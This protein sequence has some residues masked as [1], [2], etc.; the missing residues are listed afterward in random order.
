MSPLGA[1]T[2][3]GDDGVVPGSD[4]NLI[5]DDE[6]MALAV[7]TAARVR[8]S[9]APNPWVG[10]AIRT[11]D[12]AIHTGAT[13][14]PGGAHA[15]IEAL[16]AAG[17]AAAGAT[18]ASTLEPCSHSGRTGPCTDAIIAAGIA[19]VIVGVEDP[20]ADVAGRGIARLR[21][22]GVEVEV[23]V[24]GSDVA[25]Q[26]APYLHHRR[27][28]RPY[29]VLKL[30]AT[31]DGRTAAPDGSSQWITSVDARRDAHR[32]RAESQAILVGAGTVRADNPTLTTRLV[33]G[34]DP[35]RVVL[36]TAPADA[37]VHPCLEWIGPI[38]DLLDQL[39]ADGVLQLLVEGGAGVASEFHDGGMVDRY[40]VYLAPAIFGGD[41]ARPLFV[42]AGAPTI[43][44]L[45]RGRILDA[46]R[47]GP[48]LR[49]DVVLE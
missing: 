27:T 9:T 41:D 5:S 32:L 28:G 25:E 10:A 13:N 4:G 34:P 45:R 18:L 21:D 8:T 16:H 24:G 3:L 42:G 26:L 38:P 30:A 47:I 36:G 31:L 6:L 14:P 22:A 29:V 39:G 49:V 35:S 7:A 37:A 15:E 17:D 2:D 48:D 20:D 40:V 33:D 12:G 43:D 1:P 11:A 23:G 46:R 44:E 19:R